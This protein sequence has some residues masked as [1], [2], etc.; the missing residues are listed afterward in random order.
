MFVSW[1]FAAAAAKPN[2][3]FIIADDLGWADVAFHGGRAPTPNL[4]RLA[5]ESL[6][7]TQHYVYPVCSPTRAAL[8]SGRYATRFGVTNPQNNRAYPWD[9]VTLARALKAAGYDTAI[10]GKW[11]LGSK[12][13]WGPQKYGFDHGYGSLAGG[14]GPWDHRYKMGEFSITWHRNGQLIEEQGHVT[15]LITREAVQWI[16]SRT[17]KPFFLYVPFTAVHIPIREP[18]EWVR[19]V[20]ASV[21]EPAHR[22]LSA[23][24]M[25]LDDSV[26]KILAA[27]KQAGKADNTL[28]IFTSDNGGPN[29]R[30]ND[31]Q[32]PADNYVAGQTGGNNLPLR[33]QKAQVYEGGTRVATLAHWP[34]KLKPGKF[35]G[36]AHITDWMPTF[37]ALAG[38]KPDRDLRWDGRNLWP[39]LT[40]AE[41]PKPRV[42]YTA[43][44]G[45]RARALRDGDWKLIVTDGNAGKKDGKGAAERIELFNLAKD[46]NETTDLAAKM[47]EK[48]A[49]LRALLTEASLADKDAVAKD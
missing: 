26:G 7:L 30:N 35:N 32:Y 5:K 14:V 43:A 20:P 24:V 22:E 40:G 17:D 25:H 49:E 48:I 15:D 3:V 19:R 9:T 6:E 28:V 8:L 11:H 47:P 2:F 13:E 12:P 31:T 45:F 16:G 42:L 4:D 37:C 46:P 44:P 29:A 34:G 33:G 27:L 36:V 21:T 18:E 39:Q 1:N 38:Y 41:K 23:S 10:T